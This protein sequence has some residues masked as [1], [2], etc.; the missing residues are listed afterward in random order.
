MLLSKH[1]SFLKTFIRIT[2]KKYIKLQ[3]FINKTNHFDKIQPNQTFI[4]KYK[5]KF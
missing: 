4:L 1:M 3:Q 5:L 2:A